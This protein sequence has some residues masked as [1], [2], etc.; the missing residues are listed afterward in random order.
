MV[1]AV[2]PPLSGLSFAGLASP[3]LLHLLP[4]ARC[5]RSAAPLLPSHLLPVRIDLLS[6]PANLSWHISGLRAP[7]GCS[8]C[9]HSPCLLRLSASLK[10]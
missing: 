6:Q 10:A 3:V 8:L 7:A 9:S 5:F 4:S 1:L 2:H